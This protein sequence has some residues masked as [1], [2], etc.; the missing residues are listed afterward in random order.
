MKRNEFI[1]NLVRAG[2]FAL[3]GLLVFSLKNRISKG[4]SCSSCP[5]IDR[6]PGK[7]A[8]TKY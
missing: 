5:E 1:K 6:C 4:G 8:C 2:L 7:N 3:L